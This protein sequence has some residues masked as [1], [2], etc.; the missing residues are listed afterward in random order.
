[1]SS[2]LP[3][4]EYKFTNIYENEYDDG[5]IIYFYCDN[6]QEWMHILFRLE[7]Y[8][9]EMILIKRWYEGISKYISIYEINNKK[10]T[11]VIC[12]F[13]HNWELPKTVRQLIYQIDKPDVVIY[14]QRLWKIV[15]GIENTETCFVWNATRQRHGRMMWFINKWY[16]FIFFAYYSKKDKSNDDVRKPSPLF[17][18]S[19]L[20]L[21][22]KTSTPTVLS[23]YDH[24]DVTQRIY[25]ENWVWMIDSR[26]ET[27]SY[28]LS[29]IINWYDSTETK[30]KLEAC[31]KDMI[32]YYDKSVKR[33]KE[34][35]L[36]KNTMSLLRSKD[37]EKIL[38]EKIYNR[39]KDFSF[40]PWKFGDALFGW[41]PV[42]TID[43]HWKSMTISNFIYEKFSWINFYQLSPKCPVWITFDTKSL[44]QKLNELNDT[45]NY[46]WDD[47]LDEKKPTIVILLKLT[48]KWKLELPD[49]YNWRIAAFYELYAQSFWELNSM[50]LLIDHSD[51]NEYNPNDAKWS[52]IF[53]TID[54]Y[55]TILTD[56]DFNVL[57]KNSDKAKDDKKSKYKES[58]TEDNVTCFF[59]TILKQEWIRPS[60]INPPCWSWSDMRL[61]PTDKFFYIDRNDD[62][63][64][65]AYY[66]PKNS[67]IWLKDNTYYVGESK[68]W[69]KEFLSIKN[70][71]EQIVRINSMIE[72]IKNEMDKLDTNEFKY[73]SFIIFEWQKKE[74]LS[75]VEEIRAWKRL[76]TDYVAV[77]EEFKQEDSDIRL[78]I[79]KV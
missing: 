13:Y 32:F 56:L 67:S 53:K 62:R 39:D 12:S 46:Y 29:L 19:F 6:L 16:P 77:I 11:I 26:K 30:T 35:E 10:Y 71:D 73:E 33:V 59:E 41:K 65:I 7:E 37:L 48:K 42:A 60:F 17:V 69:Y 28:I 61:Y 36:P 51:K 79:I 78:L 74:A 58:I 25:D 27:L 14:N 50:I 66:R 18:L 55:A 4:N 49:P 75:L 21:S 64:D 45:W 70:Y 76:W 44:I 9:K 52:K 22:I 40:F 72:L 47:S 57:D 8:N 54:K 31:L 2:I 24:E 63:P 20:S 34:N 38:L 1:M 3:L 23:L 68:A 15:C 5:E 43:L